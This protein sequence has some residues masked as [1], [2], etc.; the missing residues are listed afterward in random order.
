MRLSRCSEQSGHSV[1]TAG[2]AKYSTRQ[3][4]VLQTQW[5]K[6]HTFI[7]SL[8]LQVRRLSG[9]SHGFCSWSPGAEGTVLAGQLSP[10]ARGRLCFRLL[11]ALSRIQILMVVGLRSPFPL[12]VGKAHPYLPE[13]PPR[14]P[15][16]SEHG[17]AVVRLCFLSAP[18]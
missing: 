16:A 15:W 1:N 11:Q 17:R 5:L 2:I 8:F 7:I 14:D 6:R 10:G 12:A 13:A 18:R 3:N 4:K 9:L